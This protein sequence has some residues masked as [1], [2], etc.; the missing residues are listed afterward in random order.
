MNKKNVYIFFLLTCAIL[1]TPSFVHAQRDTRCWTE[2][3][4]KEAQGVFYQGAETTTCGN[5]K[6]AA[7]TKIGFCLP[8]GTIDTKIAL[9]GQTRF[10]NLGE[11]F[12]FV[13]KYGIQIAGIFAVLFLVIGGFQWM[14]SGGSTDKIG[15]AKDRMKNAVIG[16]IILLL[17]F[18]ILDTINPYLTSFRLPQVYMINRVGLLEPSCA[19]L[20]D[21]ERIA[22]ANKKPGQAID[23][24]KFSTALWNLK[25]L[26]KPKCGLDYF[27]EGTGLQTCTG[28]Y[29][30]RTDAALSTAKTCYTKLDKK[31][32]SCNVG[33]I[34]GIISHS[35]VVRR[36][37]VQEDNAIINAALTIATEGWTWPWADDPEIYIVCNDGEAKQLAVSNQHPINAKSPHLD[38][39]YYN[40]KS[41]EQEYVISITDEE[42]DKAPKKCGSKSVKGFIFSLEF[43]EQG[44]PA[45]EEHYM[46]VDRK[47]GKAIDFGDHENKILKIVPKELFLTAQEIKEGIPINVDVNLIH[48]IDDDEPDRRTY[49]GYLGYK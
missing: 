35:D 10:A 46:G 17:S 20:G 1:L 12:K 9:Q 44:D 25:G 21:G 42:L 38:S 36:S 47:T 23:E 6:N 43:N 28:Y 26:V 18:L 8:I 37:L 22:Q 14:T 24:K 19:V 48:D 32:I 29:C 40:K 33:N 27:V 49:Y 3:G 39:S 15:S 4:C 7:G 2:K 45:F 31:N 30:E 41:A 11:Y 34:G 16:L 5:P 13:Y